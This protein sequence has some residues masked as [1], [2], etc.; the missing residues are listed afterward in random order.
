MN[1]IEVYVLCK[2]RSKSVL[3]KFLN[4]F[5]P[6]RKEAAE[7]YSYPQY[8][9]NP[10]KVYKNLSD[11]LK[12][13]EKETFADYSLYW[14]NITNCAPFTAMVFFTSDGG[15]IAGLAVN[16]EDGRLYLEQ[17]R[18]F[19]N[20]DYGYTI[21]ESV[22]PDNAADFIKLC[23]NSQYLKLVEKKIVVSVARQL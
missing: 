5:L 1:E 23:Q 18:D 17:L 20:A 4:R 10:E 12:I 3:D 11:L 6:K 16:E 19:W 14:N 2:K 8:D 13:I 15:M 21:F 7:E 22:P 9:E